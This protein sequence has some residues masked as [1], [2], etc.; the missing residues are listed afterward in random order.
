MCRAFGLVEWRWRRP[1]LAF[2]KIQGLPEEHL[3]LWEYEFCGDGE[4]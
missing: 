2:F 4:G 1:F 3:T